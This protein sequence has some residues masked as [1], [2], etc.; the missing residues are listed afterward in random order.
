[1]SR[2]GTQAGIQK[3]DPRDGPGEGELK[4]LAVRHPPGYSPSHKRM[5]AAG[6]IGRTRG[7]TRSV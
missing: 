2:A 6:I 1:M 7:V 3:M 5:S 4:V